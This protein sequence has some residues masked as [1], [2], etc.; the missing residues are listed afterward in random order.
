MA[1][2]QYSFTTYEI[3]ENQRSKAISIRLIALISPLRPDA[4]VILFVIIVKLIQ[5]AERFF[6]QL[7]NWDAVS[8]FLYFLWNVAKCHEILS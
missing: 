7:K 4:N 8:R 3:N 2:L 6:K 5:P 1:N